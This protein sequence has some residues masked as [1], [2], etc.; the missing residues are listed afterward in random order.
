M[1][2]N[3]FLKGSEFNAHVRLSQKL[4]GR[5]NF[6]RFSWGLGVKFFASGF[7]VGLK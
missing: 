2:G 1:L 5:T 6:K 7:I 4:F 3:I